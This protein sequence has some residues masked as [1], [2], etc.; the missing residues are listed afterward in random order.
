[1]AT[2][3]PKLS[4]EICEAPPAQQRP[5][6]GQSKIGRGVATWRAAAEAAWRPA[7]C[8][9]RGGEKRGN[10]PERM[11]TQADTANTLLVSQ[12]QRAC[13][14]AAPTRHSRTQNAHIKL[15]PSHTDS[16]GADIHAAWLTGARYSCREWGRGE[17]SPMIEPQ[18]RIG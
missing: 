10:T 4:R 5:K 12:G 18:Q 13:L 3:Q 2:R 17:P 7:I 11:S 1:M 14:E 8:E 6:R 16:V 15:A 9:E